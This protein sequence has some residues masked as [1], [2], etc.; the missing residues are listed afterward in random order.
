MWLKMGIDKEEFFVVEL[1]QWNKIFGTVNTRKCKI[2]VILITSNILPEH[3][4]EK[5][6]V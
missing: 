5:I 4:K 2:I 3:Q 1:K 6:E